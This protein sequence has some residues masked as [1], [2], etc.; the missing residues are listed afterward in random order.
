MFLFEPKHRTDLEWCF[1]NEGAYSFLDRTGRSQFEEVRDR[2]NSWFQN[3]PEDHQSWLKN[4]F[5]NEDFGTSFFELYVHQ[6]FFE[7]GYSTS[8]HTLEPKTGLTPDFLISKGDEC[9]YVEAT[10][11]R[12]ASEK[13]DYEKRRNIIKERLEQI[14]QDKLWLNIQELRLYTRRMFK[15]TQL[16]RKLLE[17]I[18][19]YSHISKSELI[20]EFL[21]EDD[22]IYFKLGFLQIN[23]NG[24]GPYQRIGIDASFDGVWGDSSRSIRKAILKKAKKYKQLPHPLIIALNVQGPTGMNEEDVQA[25]LYGDLALQYDIG[26]PEKS[27]WSRKPNGLLNGL[28]R[29]YMSNVHSIIVTSVCESHAGNEKVMEIRIN[30]AY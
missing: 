8:A 3:Y 20:P 24:P 1:A 13:A 6:K 30:K 25:A 15:T 5:K 29:R 12:E 10:T 4:R 28:D 26:N 2:L 19:Q 9:F 18:E 27:Y 17:H 14:K 11:T 22:K 7:R 23:G 16:E 21:Y